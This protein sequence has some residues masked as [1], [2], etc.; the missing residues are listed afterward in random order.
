M[1]ICSEFQHNR[2]STPIL[3]RKTVLQFFLL[4]ITKN[5]HY[6]PYAW[7]D[8]LYMFLLKENFVLPHLS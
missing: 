5:I 2:K 4:K 8:A 6:F 1:L 3:L 7:N